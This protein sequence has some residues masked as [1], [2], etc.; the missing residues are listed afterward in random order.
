MTFD[1]E[2]RARQT[3]EDVA[4]R[5]LLARQ[6]SQMAVEEKRASVSIEVPQLVT[7]RPGEDG[8]WH[9]EDA[10]RNGVLGR[11]DGQRRRTARRRRQHES[12]SRVNDGNE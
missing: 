11:I 9:A 7:H 8:M 10:W 1:T 6:R 5:R 12:R 2:K 4:A 3:A